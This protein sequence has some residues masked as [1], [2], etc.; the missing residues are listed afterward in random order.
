MLFPLLSRQKIV[1]K[2]LIIRIES[3]VKKN[4]I[5]ILK[6]IKSERIFALTQC[7]SWK[8]KFCNN[9]KSKGTLPLI[10]KQN[11]QTIRIV[12]KNQWNLTVYQGPCD[13]WDQNESL[14]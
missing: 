11:T 12:G 4:L 2:K 10:Y 14:W 3:I 5:L 9:W 6:I 8:I 13:W 1:I 7:N